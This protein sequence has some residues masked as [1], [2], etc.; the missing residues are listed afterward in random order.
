MVQ[1]LD[2]HGVGCRRQLIPTDLWPGGHDDFGIHQRRGV[3]QPLKQV[4]RFEVEHRAER[5][6]H[7]PSWWFHDRDVV[8]DR[9]SDEPTRRQDDLRWV[10]ER[11]RHGRQRHRAAKQ[12]TV[13]ISAQAVA[14]T[15]LV[16]RHANDRWGEQA[17]GG[18]HAHRHAR[19][20]EPLGGDDRPDI[21][22]VAHHNLRLL[23]LEQWQQYIGPPTE[24]GDE[25][26]RHEG[27]F[28]LPVDGA[29]G[30]RVDA[31]VSGP[32]ISVTNPSSESFGTTAD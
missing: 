23:T 20:P 13:R 2:E 1:L 10:A 25:V 8:D 18:D 12:A 5:R 21:D 31:N 19:D 30:R 26:L 4:A 17:A 6:I 32:T 16:P 11:P 7:E 29:I 22:L 9:R 3:D 14:R 27:P 24:T 15:P 28:S